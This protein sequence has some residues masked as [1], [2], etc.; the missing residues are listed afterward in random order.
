MSARLSGPAVAIV[1]AL[2]ARRGQDST[3][4]AEQTGESVESVREAIDRLRQ[5]GWVEE[6]AGSGRGRAPEFGLTVGGLAAFYRTLG[7]IRDALAPSQLA[8]SLPFTVETVWRECLCF[9]YLVEPAVLRSL[10]PAVFELVTIAGRA[11]VSVAA[12]S[13][14]SMRP[15]GL[16]DLVG[17]NFCH[18]TYR[19]VV[20]FKHAAGQV[21]TGY[22]F[23]ASMTNSELLSRIGNSVTEFRFH[24]F[25][26]GTITFLRQGS[27]VVLGAEGD[28]PEMTIVASADLD[29]GRD[30]PP[31]TSVFRSRGELNSL[32]LD[33]SDAFGHVPGNAHVYVLRIDRDAWRY[34]FVSPRDRYLGYFQEGRPF[35]RHTA[36]LDSVLH[37][38][39]IAYR[40]QPLRREAIA[41]S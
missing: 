27:N 25:R 20:R 26:T 12:A 6:T 1:T 3:E 5:Q 13:L 9:N 7:E 36:Q 22:D 23:I 11:I 38:R 14:T 24:E 21:R 15:R 16:P 31:S 32:V 17:Q 30:S 37:C 19:A 10:V 29:Q 8:G 2:V 28:T 18:I 41:A 39:D 33:Y 35:D 34:R 4:L 40:W